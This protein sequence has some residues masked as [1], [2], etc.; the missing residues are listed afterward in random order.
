M[1]GLCV[2]LAGV[3]WAEVPVGEFTLAWQHSVERVRWEE[4]YRAT[5]TGLLLEAARIKGSGA[6]MEPPDDA[7]LRAGSWHYRP[8]LPPLQPLRLGRTPE[9]GDYQI[10][11]GGQCHDLAQ[12]IGPPNPDQPAVELWAC[13]VLAEQDRP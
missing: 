13:R 7:E 1:I 11:F 2:G 6:G 8:R 9:A 12:W 3:I 5:P 4:D 10:C